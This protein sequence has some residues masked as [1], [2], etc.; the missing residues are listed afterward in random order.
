MLLLSAS[1][2]LVSFSHP[3]RQYRQW[4]APFGLFYERNSSKLAVR[5]TYYD[6]ENETFA[7]EP[8]VDFYS[9]YRKQ[10]DFLIE[11]DGYNRSERV[12][13]PFR[14]DFRYRPPNNTNYAPPEWKKGQDFQAGVS[15]WPPRYSLTGMCGDMAIRALDRLSTD[16]DVPFLLSIHFD[17]PHPGFVVSQE[18]MDYYW[19]HR[20]QLYIPP[21]ISDDMGN[22]AYLKSALRNHHGKEGYLHNDKSAMAEVTAAYYGMVEE[23][24]EWVGKMLDKLRDS[25]LSESTLVVFTSDHGEL[26]GAHGLGGKVVHL[27]ESVRVPLILSMPTNVPTGEVVSDPVSHIDLHATFLD[28]AGASAHDRSDGQSLRRFIENTA[29]NEKYDDGAVISE[30]DLRLPKSTSEF[31]R[32]PGMLPSFMIRKGHWKLLL[33]KLRSSRILD[34]M[35]DLSKDP[36]EMH[37]YL[38]YNSDDASDEVIAKSEHLKSLLVEWMKRNDGGDKRYYSDNR[39]NL[40]DG[41]GDIAEIQAR[42]TWRGLDYWQSDSRLTFGKPAFV[43]GQYRRNE[44]LYIGRTNPGS[45]TVSR[46]VVSGTHASLFSLKVDGVDM[47]RTPLFVIQQDAHLRIQVAF[48]S[49]HSPPASLDARI[50]I[51]NTVHNTTTILIAR[52]L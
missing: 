33:P 13:E 17:A 23:V 9:T 21:S 6:H 19:K 3:V 40:G 44:Y 30:L 20:D 43:N 38:G 52:E 12:F 16:D 26:L 36:Y 8:T 49:P 10:I 48:A 14:L 11:R 2:W 4:H 27:E 51:Y 7:F 46:M 37:N 29:Y 41:E 32:P 42:R 5:S 34:M 31:N 18:Y 15:E 22:S 25:G 39:Y 45:T 35:Y 1:H 24:D 47:D 28:Y 50:E